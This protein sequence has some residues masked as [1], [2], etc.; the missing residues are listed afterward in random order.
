MNHPKNHEYKGAHCPNCNSD[1]IESS[2]P[3]PTDCDWISM[4]VKCLECKHDWVESYRL[5]GYHE[6]VDENG[7]LVLDELSNGAGSY[8]NMIFN[9]KKILREITNASR[10]LDHPEILESIIE[11]HEEILS[12]E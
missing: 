9:Y 4:P 3:E 1:Q 8:E 10:K 6:L 2:S 11:K 7:E 5:N 12:E